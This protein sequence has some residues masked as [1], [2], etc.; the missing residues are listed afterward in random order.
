[1]FLAKDD[2][3]GL[4]PRGLLHQRLKQLHTSLGIKE[5]WLQHGASIKRKQLLRFGKQALRS[6]L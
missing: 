3:L 4:F 5:T 6:H 2:H 1:M